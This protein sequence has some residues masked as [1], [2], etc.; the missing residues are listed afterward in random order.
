M[1][2]FEE[3]FKA[4]I[5]EEEGSGNSAEAIYKSDPKKFISFPYES[6]QEEADDLGLENPASTFIIIADLSNED[7]YED[8]FNSMEGDFNNPMNSGMQFVPV[9]DNHV[10]RVAF[11]EDEMSIDDLKSALGDVM[12]DAYEVV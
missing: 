12:V 5:K 6:H 8:K 7:A 4:F 2:L 1:L 9:G 10:G 11:F 3:K